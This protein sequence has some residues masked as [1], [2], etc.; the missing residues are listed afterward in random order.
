MSMTTLKCNVLS[1]GTPHYGA[2]DVKK[3][4]DGNCKNVT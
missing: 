2:N 1:K 3:F 4:W